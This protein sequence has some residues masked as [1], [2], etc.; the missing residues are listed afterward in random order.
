[1]KPKIVITHKIHDSVLD[2]L[3]QDCELVTNQ[4]GA[5]LPQEEV[6]A[7][8]ADADAMM[9]F[10]PDRVGVEFLQGCPRLKVIG[11]AL[12]GYDNFDVDACTRHGVWLTFVP[13][14]LT[15]PTAELTVGLTISLT[16]QVKAADHFVRSGE[17]TGWTPRFYGQGIEGSRIGIVGMG[18]IGQAVA[19][20][21]NGWG[22]D[23]I[24]SQP[25]R[26]PVQHEQALGL[27]H[28]PLKMLLAQSD[29]VILALALN[30]QTLHTINRET[31]TGMKPGAFL[32]NPCRGSVVD[33]GSVLQALQSGQ[34]G[35]YAAD[36]FE[37]EDWAREDRP[38]EI[39]QGLRAHPN[40]LFTAHIGSA[41]SQVRLA[42]EQR[43]ARNILQV[44]R[45]ERPGDAINDPSGRESG[46]C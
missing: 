39:A 35:G 31:L 30:E 4:S 3:A 15:V 20:R 27:S 34:L 36:V 32:I 41:V 45:G 17:F 40:T 10:M 38:R 25:E 42:I 44:L 14:L 12:K 6:A 22:A 37:M 46:P 5:T 1:M 2:E 24:Y 7:R 33:E 16:R 28:T 43:A 29:I 18:A 13:D 9:A 19:Q 21:L 23:L 8:V 11:A 26:L